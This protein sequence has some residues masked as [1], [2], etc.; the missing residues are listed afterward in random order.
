MNTKV[1][2][3]PLGFLLFPRF[4]L[5]VGLS[6][7]TVQGTQNY[8]CDATTGTF[9]LL[10]IES[11]MFS[12]GKVVGF[13][14]S[15]PIDGQGVAGVY[16]LT[17]PNT[18]EIIGSIGAIRG[19]DEIATATLLPGALPWFVKKVAVKTGV[20]ESAE[21]IWRFATNGGYLT[22]EREKN[23]TIGRDDVLKI[24]YNASFTVYK[25]KEPAAA[26]VTS[27]STRV[28]VVAATAVAALAVAALIL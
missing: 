22:T 21:Y 12:D 14:L 7:P 5:V 18:D 6:F 13:G 8:T 1:S 23:C 19:E 15:T 2:N 9:T 17:D 26:G 27:T 10:G 11:Q 16:Y 24:P 28:S 20:F 3:S 25:C 4:N